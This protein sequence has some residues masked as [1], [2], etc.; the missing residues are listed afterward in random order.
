VQRPKVEVLTLSLVGSNPENPS[1]FNQIFSLKD[2]LES[3]NLDLVVKRGVFTKFVMGEDIKSD[4]FSFRCPKL[5]F[6]TDARIG[7]RRNPQ[8]PNRKQKIFGFNAVIDTS[9]ELDLGIEL[10]S[11][12]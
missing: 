12:A 2:K 7:V 3:A 8:N 1:I 6:D 5:P 10:L 11:E 4:S 9:I